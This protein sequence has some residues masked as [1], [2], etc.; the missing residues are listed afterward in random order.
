[1]NPR[2]GVCLY[3]IEL[4]GCLN[5]LFTNEGAQGEIFNEIC[6]RR[7]EQSS[8]G[9]LAGTYDCVYFDVDRV[10]HSARL[11]ITVL[12]NFQNAPNAPRVFRF[13]WQD[14]N[15]PNVVLFEG[16]GYL[17]NPNQVVVRYEGA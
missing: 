4:D 15:N 1:M 9:T 10:S 3:T 12:Q 17:I 2:L 14:V 8:Q 13:E 5:G 7:P 16:T 6:K 11:T